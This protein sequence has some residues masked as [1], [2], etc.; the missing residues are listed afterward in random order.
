MLG[1]F[2]LVVVSVWPVSP[3]DTVDEVASG[4]GS[5]VPSPLVSLLVDEL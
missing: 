2:S 3:E 1:T 4:I 5:V